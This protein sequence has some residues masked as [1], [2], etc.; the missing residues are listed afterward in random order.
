VATNLIA[1]F[2]R[3]AAAVPAC[4]PV[5]L[6][7]LK[8]QYAG[9]KDEV[10]DAVHRVLASQQLILG[11][12]VEAFETEIARYVGTQFAIGCGSGSDALLL[13]LMALG[14]GPQDEVITSPFTFGATAGAIARLARVPS[15]STSILRP[16][17]WTSGK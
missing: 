13:T 9:I 12:E 7:D 2:E 17:T 1:Q 11:P 6:L 14:V 8:A 10:L 4:A 5:S 3:P 16:S 15:L